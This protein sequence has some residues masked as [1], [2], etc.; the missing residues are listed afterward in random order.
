MPDQSTF[1]DAEAAAASGVVEVD[2]PDEVP[3]VITPEMVERLLGA[4]GPVGR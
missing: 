4:G 3:M 1:E 2:R